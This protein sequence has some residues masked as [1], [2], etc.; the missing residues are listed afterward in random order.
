MFSKTIY[1]S[2]KCKMSVFLNTAKTLYSFY[3]PPPKKKSGEGLYRNHLVPMSVR[4]FVQSC[5]NHIFI[6]E[7]YW[8]FLLHTNIA[9]LFFQFLKYQTNLYSLQCFSSWI[10]ISLYTWP[11]NKMI[12]SISFWRIQLNEKVT[13]VPVFSNHSK[14]FIRDFWDFEFI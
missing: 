13:F 9:E 14:Y 12:I 1:I 4:S 11:W 2:S 3:S 6:M 10:C 7:D 5:P 8:M